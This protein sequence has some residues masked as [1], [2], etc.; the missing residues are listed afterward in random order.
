M[1]YVAG[2]L[3]KTVKLIQLA[4]SLREAV[5][6]NDWRC[7]RMTVKA[8][9]YPGF[10]TGHKANLRAEH[11]SICAHQA[12]EQLRIVLHE[13]LARHQTE[14]YRADKPLPPF[15]MNDVGE[16]SWPHLEKSGAR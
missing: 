15:E 4:D 5:V 1:K 6:K 12:D 2:K 9:Q 11:Y 16:L 14:T 7:L 3:L 8:M 10:E 13:L